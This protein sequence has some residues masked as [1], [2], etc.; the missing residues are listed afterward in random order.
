[1]LRKRLPAPASQDLGL[2]PH[3]A[4]PGLNGEMIIGDQ[5]RLEVG[6]AAAQTRLVNLV[7]GDWL[8]S[9]PRD[10]YNE[11]IAGLAPVGPLGDH[12]RSVQAGRG[13]I[14]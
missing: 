12:A 1:M 14:P 3:H 13:A 8:L 7:H 11:G 4:G 9:A 2:S 10:A 6:F 5:A